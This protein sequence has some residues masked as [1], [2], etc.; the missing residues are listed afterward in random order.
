ML[1]R[2]LTCQLSAAPLIILTMLAANRLPGAGIPAAAAPAPRDAVTCIDYLG[3]HDALLLSNGVA[4][5]VIVP[6]IGRVMQFRFAGEQDGPFW[7]NPTL[8]GQGLN[9]AS[10]DWVNLGGDKAWPSPQAA[11]SR[12]ARR[13]WPPP[14][15]FDGLPMEAA[16]DGAA[17]ILLS[18]V[19]PSYGMRV[20]RRIELAADRPVMTITTRYEK[21]AGAAM[22]VGVWTITQTRDPVAVYAVLPDAPRPT[23]AYVRM[24]DE[25]PANLTTGEGLVGLTRAP[26]K[27]R[28]IGA[29]AGTLVWVGPRE[30]LR[31]DSP[32]VPGARYPDEGSSVEIYTNEDP[33]AYVELEVLGPV[34]KLAVGDHSER[35]TIYTLARRTA[36]DPATEVRR[37]LG[38]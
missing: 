33:L 23:S 9:P 10:S 37:L 22:E 34:E 7:A 26:Q 36:K 3:W 14:V 29:L 25:L 32:L 6:A 13:G 24:S 5:V 35:Q 2:K 1:A 4:E 20:R 38:R 8:L 12:V 15:G 31:I 16:R 27:N 19:D 21:V 17:V 18:A 11:W 28:K 30:L